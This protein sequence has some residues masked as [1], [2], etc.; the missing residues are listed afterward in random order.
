MAD[1]GTFLDELPEEQR[2]YVPPSWEEVAPHFAKRFPGLDPAKMQADYDQARGKAIKQTVQ[3]YHLQSA[4]QELA[5][6][7]ETT[8]SYLSRH[9]LPGGSALLNFRQTQEYN[10]ARKRFEAGEAEPADYSTI[11]GYERIQQL[12]QEKN[13]TVLGKLKTAAVS[14]PAM[15]GEFAAGGAVLKGLGAAGSLA[16]QSAKVAVPIWTGRLAAQTSMVPSLYAKQ[17]A[18]NNMEQGRDPL[19]FRG[20]PAAFGVALV[21]NAILGTLGNQVTAIAPKLGAAGALP[22]AGRQAAKGVAGVVESG[23]A[24]AATGKAQDAVRQYLPEWTRKETHYGTVGDMADGKYGEAAQNA[25]VQALTFAAFGAMHEAQH[26]TPYRQRQQAMAQGLRQFAGEVESHQQTEV[27]GSRFAQEAAKEGPPVEALQDYYREMGK[28]GRSLEAANAGLDIVHDRV[29]QVMEKNQNPD[30]AEVGKA[31]ED[32]P[33]T[34]PVKKYAEWVAS[35]FP[36]KAAPEQAP[37]KA[38]E[39]PPTAPQAQKAPE[40]AQAPATPPEAASA[41]KESMVDALTFSDLKELASGLGIKTGGQSR[42]KL[43]EQVRKVAGNDAVLEQMADQIINPK[44]PE[45]I[46]PEQ[47]AEELRAGAAVDVRHPP[48]EIVK[49]LA[50][51]QQEGQAAIPPSEVQEIKDL[52]KTESVSEPTMQRSIVEPQEVSDADRDLAFRYMQRALG[53]TRK[54]FDSIAAKDRGWLEEKV[55]D[56]RAELPQTEAKARGLASGKITVERSTE[57]P[58]YHAMKAGGEEVGH[59]I[60]GDPSERNNEARAAREMFPVVKD[61]QRVSRVH[62]VEVDDAAKGKG[63]GQRLI[64]DSMKEHG[65]DWY[66]NSQASPDLVHA[67]EALARKGQAELHWHKKPEPGKE[68]GPFVVRPT[69]QGVVKMGAKPTLKER[70]LAK[71]RA[72]AAEAKAT[73][74]EEAPRPVRAEEAPVEESEK[75]T[76]TK[77]QEVILRMQ[78]SGMSLRGM[79][80]ALNMSHEQARTLLNQARAAEGKTGSLTEEAAAGRARSLEVAGEEA[81]TKK[82]TTK[83]GKEVEVIS[84]KAVHEADRAIRELADLTDEHLDE[85]LGDESLLNRLKE[86]DLTRMELRAKQE[87]QDALKAA[88]KMGANA[89]RVKQLGEQVPEGEKG[90]GGRREDPQKAGQSEVPQEGLAQTGEAAQPA[91]GATQPE[92]KKGKKKEKTQADLAHEKLLAEQEA[93]RSRPHEEQVAYWAKEGLANANEGGAQIEAGIVGENGHPLVHGQT[94]GHLIL[95]GGRKV[96]LE[97]INMIQGEVGDPVY[98]RDVAE[99]MRRK[100][101]S[102]ELEGYN[103]KDLQNLRK[104]L[105]AE[106]PSGAAETPVKEGFG[107]PLSPEERQGGVK[108]GQPDAGEA[109]VEMKKTDLSKEQVEIERRKDKRE[110]LVQAT[111][112]EDQVVA[113]AVDARLAE[114]PNAGFDLVRELQKKPRPLSDEDAALL[115]HHKTQLRNEYD[116]V[117]HQAVRAVQERYKAKG[118]GAETPEHLER[119]VELERRTDDLDAA[120]NEFDKVVAPSKTATARGLRWLGIVQG[121]DFS[122]H[123]M[124]QRLEVAKKAPLTREETEKVAGLH[125]KIKTLQDRIKELEAKGAK[126]GSKEGE[127]LKERRVDRVQTVRQYRRMVDSARDAALSVPQKILRGV[128]GAWDASRALMTAYDLSFFFRQG[129]LVVGSLSHPIKAA[130]ALFE[131]VKAFGSERVADRVMDEIQNNP[132]YTLSRR[133]DLYLADKDAGLSSQEEAF[134]GRW[135]KKIPGIA[136]SE[137]AYNTFLNRMRMSAFDSLTSAMPG[138]RATDAQAATIAH[139]I[140]VAT[141]RG[142]LGP[143]EKAAVGLSRILFSP[144]FLTSRFQLLVG[145]PLWHG[146][147]HTRVALAKEFARSLLA[148]GVVYGLWSLNDDKAKITFDPRSSDF[149]K[150]VVGNTHIDPL[151]GLAQEAVFGTRIVSGQTRSTTSGKVSDLRGDKVKFGGQTVSDVITRFV[152]SKLAPIPGAAWDLL[153]GKNVV[154]QPVT[155]KPNLPF[156]A[157]DILSGKAPR[158]AEKVSIP[159][160][161]ITPLA[162]KD[163]WQAMEDQGAPKGVIAGLLA[164]LGMG[165]QV[166]EPKK[167]KVTASSP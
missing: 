68:S 98:V 93:I 127:E 92:V 4:K 63:H 141:G 17:W 23:I 49:A 53:L 112:K 45:P 29:R 77:D 130:K 76:L 62:G 95:I 142:S 162:I 87:M 48:E 79:G 59:A 72:G 143:F 105:E 39:A 115:L 7:E 146:D 111:R 71:G 97:K 22:F 6:K 55:A 94:E 61:G 125:E 15:I 73:G 38:P 75:P 41:P 147:R 106:S 58:N 109:P 166:Y 16:G 83:D 81:A 107:Q 150:V 18:D 54:E 26:G 133:S 117:A 134:I 85:R 19:D 159:D 149:G 165:T 113:A 70:M 25:I 119:V 24:D 99:E 33:A 43:L 28:T 80:K 9:V 82:V 44:K 156:Q 14:A 152:R 66:F 139:A 138:G 67:L 88:R 131:A 118:Q 8:R 155:L 30:R 148:L 164:I 1:T 151:A 103:E 157:A 51:P 102:G 90:A 161:L 158:K 126:A 129:G 47:H 69:T 34:A 116:R 160:Q 154:G 20:F 136:G 84:E 42:A 123:G 96:P 114:N 74:K 163:V 145:E 56:A 108:G 135:I 31:L 13:Q 21:Q 167:K 32:I 57:D 104:R 10:K 122:L 100:Q 120:I 2:P 65:A 140:N 3:D 37:A 153:E 137:R 40:P 89:N 27:R 60:L 46:S 91:R 12:D 144:R 132:K 110:Q 101:E 64:L 128:T 124:R 50:E 86:E 11:A 5:D 121:E 35:R 52:Q 36:E 78:A